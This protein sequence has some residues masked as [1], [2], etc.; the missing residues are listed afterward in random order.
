MR[1]PIGQFT[2]PAK[3]VSKCY[4]ALI[5]LLDPYFYATKPHA[6]HT[7]K[8]LKTCESENL[9]AILKTKQLS[10]LHHFITVTVYSFAFLLV[11][12]SYWRNVSSSS[13]QHETAKCNDE[14]KGQKD[15]L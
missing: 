15:Q 7:K 5:R 1:S 11:W 2:D 4:N 10:H 13:S 3:T 8:M 14:N 12:P 6:I 9:M